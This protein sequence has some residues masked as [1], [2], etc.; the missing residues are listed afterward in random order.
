MCDKEQP[1]GIAVVVTDKVKIPGFCEALVETTLQGQIQDG[2]SVLVDPVQEDEEMFGL[3]YSV[4]TV[5]N[6]KIKV[7]VANV[8]AE[9]VTLDKDTRVGTAY[10]DFTTSP[11]RLPP[12]GS[13]KELQLLRT[14]SRMRYLR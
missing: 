8:G 6:G 4:A 11:T 2:K 7:R 13:K 9:E 3:P 12:A 5:Q 14:N 1:N 10:K